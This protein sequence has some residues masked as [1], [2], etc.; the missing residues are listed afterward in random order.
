MSEPRKGIHSLRLFDVAVV[1]V[2]LTVM[3]AIGIS[4]WTHWNPYL[5]FFALL[6]IGIVTHRL[7]KIR[8]KVDTILF[9]DL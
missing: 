5:V 1:D 2:L 7:L 6:L 9:P 3:A 8:T 4:H